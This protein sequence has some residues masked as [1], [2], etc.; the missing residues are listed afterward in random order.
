MAG[1]W[2]EILVGNWLNPFDPR[3]LVRRGYAMQPTMW[4]AAGFVD[5]QLS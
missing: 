1:L 4:P 2:R 3:L 5:G